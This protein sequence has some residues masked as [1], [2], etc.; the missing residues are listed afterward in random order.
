[1]YKHD[2][3]A[4]SHNHC[5]RRKGRS[6][7]HSECGSGA[8]YPACKAHAMHYIVIC[9][10]SVSTIFFHIISQRH[11]FWEKVTGHKTLVSIFSTTFV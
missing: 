6:I 5:C 7:T 8:H 10:L 1:M 3:E 9:C 2:M 4:H 11:N